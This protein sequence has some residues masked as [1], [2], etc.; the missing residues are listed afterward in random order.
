MC[1][2]VYVCDVRR[3]SRCHQ[4]FPCSHT[5]EIMT[6][7]ESGWVSLEHELSEGPGMSPQQIVIEG[8]MK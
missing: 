1:A 3:V 5:L 6:H 7:S 4:L 2:R 8:G